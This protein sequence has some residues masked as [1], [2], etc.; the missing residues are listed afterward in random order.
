LDVNNDGLL[1]KS[2]LQKNYRIVKMSI[3]SVEVERIIEQADFNGNG[4]IDYTDWLAVSNCWGEMLTENKLIMAFNYFAEDG[5]IK[6]E[7]L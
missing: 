4:A 5:L 1:T 2:D 7:T 3:E 6:A